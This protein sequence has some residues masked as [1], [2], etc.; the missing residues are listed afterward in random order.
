M[1]ACRTPQ[2]VSEM[3]FN[4]VDFLIFLPTVW[5]L[6]RLTKGR[7]R[8]LI[9]LAASYF[10]Y[11]VWSIPFA[12]L[13]VISSVIDFTASRNIAASSDKRHRNIWLVVS[14]VA[15]LG[16]LVFFKYTNFLIT[17]A[18]DTAGLFGLQVAPHTLDIILPLG[19]SFYTFQTM[20]YTIDVWRGTLQPTQSFLRFALYVSF[21]PQLVAGPIV[22]AADFLPQLERGPERTATRT[23][24]GLLLVLTG[25]VK[26]MVL[27]DNIG[28]LVDLVYAQPG[29]YSGDMLL[30]ATYAFAFQI[31]LDFSG[32]TDIA[33]GVAKLLGFEFLQNFDKPYFSQ[34][35]TEFWRRWHMSLSS[36]LRD[37]L[38]IGLGG[39][40]GGKWKTYR[41]LFL[42]M[43]LGGIWHGANWT[44]IVWGIFHG[45]LLML[46]RV[47]PPKTWIRGDS[48]VAQ[49]A[50]MVVT[51]HLVCVSWVFFRAASVTDA[52]I[53][54]RGIVA[55]PWALAPEATV[56]G[57]VG[58][59]ALFLGALWADVGGRLAR[60]VLAWPRL[61]QMTLYWTGS[62]LLVG[63][64]AW[65]HAEFIYFQF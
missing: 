19:I 58:L 30:V 56:L 18:A 45:G 24:E 10:F 21:F 39:N 38:Y 3:L 16:L 26:K 29:A 12:S 50:R 63:F 55:T 60:S 42:T 40:R 8:D 14:L 51:F 35:I 6:A 47:V 48:A 33:R 41:N 34:S 59:M 5:L 54:L 13:L 37:Y 31:Y 28:P 46:E 65:T 57:S 61:A 2:P 4:S 9:L 11:M 7:L 22:R 62:L 25:L 49:V 44:F 36:W 52:W 23:R 32:Y 53:V 15:N 64:G 1:V 27:A 43:L 20:S 17:A